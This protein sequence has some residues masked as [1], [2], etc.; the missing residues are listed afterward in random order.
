M[1]AGRV[2]FPRSGRAVRTSVRP[3]Y[4]SNIEKE[5]GNVDEAFKNAA[6]VIEAEYEWPFQ[7]HAS[8]GPAC[9]L[10]EIKDGQVTCWSGTQKSHFQQQGIASTLGVPPESVRVIWKTGPGTYGRND[11]D[12]CAMDAAVLAKAVGKP[13]RLQYMRDEGTGWDPKGPASVHKVR[14]AIDS[15]GKVT[16]YEFMSKAFSRV[17]VDTNGSKT[18]D[19]LAGQTRGSDLKSGDGFGI[20]AES[21]AFD[22]SGPAGKRSRRCSTDHRRCARRT[23]AIPWDRRFT[24]PANR[25]L[26]RWLLPSMSIRSNSGCAMSRNRATLHCSRPLPKNPLAVTAIGGVIRPE[27]KV[28]PWPRLL[29]RNGTALPLSPRSISTARPA[30]PRAQVHGGMI[31]G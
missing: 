14:A 6:K 4:A 25:S 7:S 15:S 20:P 29:Q 24:S 23:C 17:D 13:V 27:T 12:D 1:V 30:R 5:N 22:N 28:G 19:T 2:A 11:A 16:A 3:A 31:A 8:M 18:F 9:A 10:V 21:Y 26:T